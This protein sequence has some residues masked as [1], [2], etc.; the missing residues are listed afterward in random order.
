MKLAVGTPSG[1]GTALPRPAPS[2]AR[3][4]P[5]F[6]AVA[7]PARAR[8]RQPCAAAAAGGPTGSGDEPLPVQPA[9]VAANPILEVER[10]S[11]R[12]LAYLGITALLGAAGLALAAAPSAAV[13]FVWAACPHPV[14]AGLAR[15]SGATLLLAAVCAHCLKVRGRAGRSARSWPCTLHGLAVTAAACAPPAA[16]P[17]PP[18]PPPR[19]V[20]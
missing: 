7:A 9:G 20:P 5:S 1:A 2:A 10:Q 11:E 4:R 14:V 19:T 6:A 16:P 12:A 8:R 17:T 3:H 15:L 13:Q 18:A